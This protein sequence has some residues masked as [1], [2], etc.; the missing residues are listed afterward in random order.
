MLVAV[1]IYMEALP[2]QFLILD[3]MYGQLLP[4][5][6]NYL[7]E[8]KDADHQ[9]RRLLIRRTQVFATYSTRAN[10]ILGDQA[11]PLLD[12]LYRRIGALR[13]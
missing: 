10:A 7:N 1:S 13:R 5:S 6:K 4:R 12:E 8:K 2:D 3:V 9:H 11:I